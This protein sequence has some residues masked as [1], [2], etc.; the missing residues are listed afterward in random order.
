M[1]FFFIFDGVDH[2]ESLPEEDYTLA[3]EL[4]KEKYEP[5][6]VG[7]KQQLLIKFHSSRVRTTGKSQDEYNAELEYMRYRLQTMHEQNHILND[8]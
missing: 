6:Q 5:N 3:W 8:Q 4:L 7:S 1:K 2:C